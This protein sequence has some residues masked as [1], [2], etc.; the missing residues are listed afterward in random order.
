MA[1]AADIVTLVQVQ[2]STSATLLTSDGLTAA[3]NNAATELG[4]SYPQTDPTRIYWL[5]K[6]ATRHSCYILWI[7]SAQNFKYKQVNL[8]HRFDHYSSVIKAM[9]LE[10]SHALE[11]DSSMFA[12]V[13]TYKQFGTLLNAGFVYNA[14][15]EDITYDDLTNYIYSGE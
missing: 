9:D 1:T 10:F 12:S 4:W 6:R 13:D 3:A 15:G 2:L 11:T 5:T 7:A 14:L 8:Q